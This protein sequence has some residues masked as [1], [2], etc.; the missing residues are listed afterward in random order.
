MKAN[1]QETQRVTHTFGM[2]DNFSILKWKWDWI[3][4]FQFLNSTELPV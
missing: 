3:T 2:D 1:N 4:N